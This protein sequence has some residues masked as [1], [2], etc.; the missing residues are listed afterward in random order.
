VD[1]DSLSAFNRM[2][3]KLRKQSPRE[4]CKAAVI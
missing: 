2:F 1:F 4:Y 3:A